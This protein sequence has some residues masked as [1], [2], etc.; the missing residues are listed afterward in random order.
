MKLGSCEVRVAKIKQPAT[1]S[2]VSR[3][4]YS[5]RSPVKI[6]TSLPA[7]VHVGIVGQGRLLIKSPGVALVCQLYDADSIVDSLL[8]S[9]LDKEVKGET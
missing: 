8:P 2:P 4:I 6:S 1:N 5:R 9:V 7:S 3:P